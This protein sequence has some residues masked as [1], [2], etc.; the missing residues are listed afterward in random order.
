M[1]F[2]DSSW[3]IENILNTAA[4]PA[5]DSEM[6]CC[7]SNWFDPVKTNIN[8]L[9]L[10][11]LSHFF[12][13]S[14]III[15]ISLKRLGA[16]CT[17]S[18]I[19]GHGCTSKNPLGFDKASSRSFVSSNVTYLNLSPKIISAVVDFPTCLGPYITIAWNDDDALLI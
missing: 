6:P 8:S 4:L 11:S 16:F 15:F 19:I 3:V 10:S 18:I 12:L 13:C 2:W 1:I 9:F 7:N 14:S 17:S 5:K